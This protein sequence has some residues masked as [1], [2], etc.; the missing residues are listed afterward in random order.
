MSAMSDVASLR[1]SAVLEGNS[2]NA[3]FIRSNLPVIENKESYLYAPRLAQH[4][5]QAPRRNGVHLTAALGTPQPLR[6]KMGLDGPS[7]TGQR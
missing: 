6:I 5:F 1:Q 3:L 7:Y 2:L 4:V